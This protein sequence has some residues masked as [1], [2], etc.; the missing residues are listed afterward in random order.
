MAAK[1]DYNESSRFRADDG[2]QILNRKNITIATPVLLHTPIRG[3]R[4]EYFKITLRHEF[5]WDLVALDM[6][7]DVNLK[8]IVMRHNRVEDP[9]I[10]PRV[11]ETYLVPT[12]EQVRVYLNRT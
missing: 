10:G 6:L 3:N 11:G 8:W 4:D 1:S 9:L 12:S 5:R 2:F 7:G